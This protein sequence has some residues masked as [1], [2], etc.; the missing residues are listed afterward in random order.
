MRG[1]VR[2]EFRVYVMYREMRGRMQEMHDSRV[3]IRYVA[4]CTSSFVGRQP[5]EVTHAH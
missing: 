4:F 3:F 5:H 2:T 1:L